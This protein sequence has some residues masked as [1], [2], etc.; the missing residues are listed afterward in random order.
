[1]FKRYK[2]LKAC[3]GWAITI[4]LLLGAA[5]PNFA[6]GSAQNPATAP[7]AFEAAT[8]KPDTSGSGSSSTNS[9]NGLL[10]ITNQT[11]QTMIQYA[12]NVRDFQIT[13]GPGWMRSDR[14]DVTAKP[15][16][17]A[18]E[19]EMKQMLQSLLAERFQLQFHRETREGPVYVLLV[20][21]T[22]SRLQPA[23]ESNNSGIDSGR[24]GDTGKSTMKGT[25]VTMAELAASLAARVGRPVID[26]TSL[27]G[28]FNF[29]LSWVPDLTLSGG[30]TN[31]APP[32]V[33]GP[34]IFTAVQE[35]LGLR[36]D[37]QKGPTEILM[38]D[39]AERPS[40]N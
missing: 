4:G 36:L 23:P 25:N 18:H 6:R 12:Y 40:E 7:L 27:T 38:I 16:N 20:G 24:S 28:R 33:S 9:T 35:Q 32:D 10:R 22:G 21:K 2:V 3:S 31:S 11:L 39:R 15:E 29:D 19:G 34:S 1:M 37:S 17:G 26:K 13:G 14:Y 8:I 5:L 30:A